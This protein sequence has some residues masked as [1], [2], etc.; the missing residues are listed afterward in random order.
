[1]LLRNR[2]QKLRGI[3]VELGSSPEVPG[4]PPSTHRVLLRPQSPGMGALEQMAQDRGH[5]PGAQAEPTG[6]WGMW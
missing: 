4:C 2:C 5:A 6:L 1:M 3:K